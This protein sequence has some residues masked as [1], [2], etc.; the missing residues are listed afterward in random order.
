MLSPEEI[1]PMLLALAVVC[2]PLAVLIAGR[3]YQAALNL[4]FTLFF[5]LPGFVHAWAVVSR[6]E[7]DRRNETVMRLA[8]LQYAS[9][10]A[11]ALA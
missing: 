11:S 3:P 7:T 5:Y 9:P 4:A 2:P 1:T 8:A 6:H 10:S